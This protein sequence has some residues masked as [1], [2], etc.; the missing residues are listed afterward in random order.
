M[1]PSSSFSPLYAE[2]G[3]SAIASRP[4]R[5]AREGQ[6]LARWGREVQVCVGVE[7]GAS[8]R[9]GD[10][11]DEATD[12]VDLEALPVALDVETDVGAG[13]AAEAGGGALERPTTGGLAV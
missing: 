7:G 6:N 2:S 11:G 5:G 1:G 12:E 10:D 4:R 8:G 3:R 13:G 9:G